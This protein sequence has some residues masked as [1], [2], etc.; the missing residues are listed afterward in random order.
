[1][2]IYGRKASVLTAVCILAALLACTLLC[3]SIV[4]WVD[5][6]K[7]GPAEASEGADRTPE[8][9]LPV[10]LPDSQVYSGLIITQ[11]KS[12]VV[13]TAWKLMHLLFITGILLYGCIIHRS[14]LIA[15]TS[16]AV[17]Q[18][19]EISLRIGGHAPPVIV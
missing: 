5:R 9:M 16:Q 2:H 12:A 14:N 4:L 15:V 7:T 1:M 19:P 10:S 11:A 17:F 18:P 6:S 13:Q 8:L 3:P